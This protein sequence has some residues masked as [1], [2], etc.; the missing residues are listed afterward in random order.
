M[1]QTCGSATAATRAAFSGSASRSQRSF[2]TVRDATGTEPIARAQAAAPATTS[3]SQS[4]ATR[5]AAASA[6][7]V[8][9]HS[10]ASR[11]TSASASRATIPCC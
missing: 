10:S 9:F 3:P 8:S 5:D 2:V 1:S 11:T 6:E 4:S 7:R